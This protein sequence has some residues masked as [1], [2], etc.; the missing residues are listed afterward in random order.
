MSGAAAGEGAGR[1]HVDPGH[2][3]TLVVTL[4][5]AQGLRYARYAEVVMRRSIK[6]WLALAMLAVPAAAQDALPK[7]LKSVRAPDVEVRF[8]DFGW[9]P[10]AFAAME[11]GGSHPAAK[12]SWM[13]ALVRLQRGMRFGGKPM[14]IGPVVLILNPKQG[15]APFS[16][17]LRDIDMRDLYFQNNVIG[18]PPAGK[19]IAVLPA[20][21]E[22]VPETKDRLEITAAPSGNDTVLTVHYGNRK[23]TVTLTGI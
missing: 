1:D 19:T 3:G 12:R 23:T 15:D 14:L 13:L 8:V 10:E 7:F 2:G 11:T 17:E 5:R 9:S 4:P 18:A 16:V 6:L 22:T 20:H 21:F